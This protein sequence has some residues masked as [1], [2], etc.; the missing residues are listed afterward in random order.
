MLS[1]I[2]NKMQLIYFY[3]NILQLYIYFIYNIYYINNVTEK[4]YM[5]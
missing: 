1:L 4:T 3:Y 2:L 5:E